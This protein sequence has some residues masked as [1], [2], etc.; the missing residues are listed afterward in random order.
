MT[1]IL[2]SNLGYAKG[3]DGSLQQH[4][5]GFGRHFYCALP[6]QSQVL[7][8]FKDLLNNEAPDICCL[9]EVD[10]GSFQSGYINQMA[11][12]MD[13]KY[14]FHDIAGK[15]GEHSRIGRMPLHKGN[16]NGFLSVSALEFKRLYFKYGTKRLVYRLSL[17][18]DVSIFLPIFHYRNLS[19]KSSLKIC[20]RLSRMFRERL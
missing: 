3:I 4:I 16:S 11:T 20:D 7:A 12:L 8:Q 19:V 15:Y 2:F 5:K 13:E 6:S 17:P 10:Q 14:Q 1:R 18:G 9:V